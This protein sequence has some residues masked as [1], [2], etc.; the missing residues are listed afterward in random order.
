MDPKYFTLFEFLH[1][2][3]AISNKLENIPSWQQI[4][5]LKELALVL[6]GVREAWGSPINIS[7]GFRTVKLNKAVGGVSNSAHLHAHAADLYVNGDIKKFAKFLVN[8]LNE[9]N[10]KFDEVI[11][12]KSG[13]STW[14]HFALK[15][16]DGKQRMKCFDI[17]K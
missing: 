5:D 4:E 12:E 2:S 13:N 16:K 15:S 3:K 8:Y 7:S 17:V 6:D 11:Y 10:I 14:V 9:N 1:S